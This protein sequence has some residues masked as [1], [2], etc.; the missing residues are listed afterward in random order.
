ML[1]RSYE[2]TCT[3][4]LVLLNSMNGG[5]WSQGDA[6]ERGGTGTAFLG[7]TNFDVET[8]KRAS[9]FATRRCSMQGRRERL[10]A[11][12][13]RGAWVAKNMAVED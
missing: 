8:K 5:S 1:Y 12:P 6:I 9:Q 10:G 4:S 11:L 2:F 7:V 13:E 3:C